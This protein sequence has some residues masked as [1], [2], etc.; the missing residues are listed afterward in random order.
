[1]NFIPPILYDK[2]NAK[3]SLL[4]FQKQERIGHILSHQLYRQKKVKTSFLKFQKKK[5]KH[6]Q[7]DIPPILY[8]KIKP[9]SSSSFFF[10]KKK[11]TSYSFPNQ[12]YKTKKDQK[13]IKFQKQ[14]NQTNY[15]PPNL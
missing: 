6:K 8:D 10:F 3:T 12:F 13:L 4:K 15:I 7:T 14:H 11:K 1:M 9:K 2:K 5:E